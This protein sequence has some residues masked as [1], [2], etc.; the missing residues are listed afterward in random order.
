MVKEKV[1]IQYSHQFKNTKKK[2]MYPDR[3]K[4]KRK[5]NRKVTV[6]TVDKQHLPISVLKVL[7]ESQDEHLGI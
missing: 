2:K 3:E 4:K 7:Y 6:N 5:R 1:V